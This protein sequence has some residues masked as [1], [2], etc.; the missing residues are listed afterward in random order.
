MKI[1]NKGWL[2]SYL[3]ARIG[4]AFEPRWFFDESRPADH[5]DQALYRIL[6]PTGLIYGQPIHFDYNGSDPLEIDEKVNIQVLMAESFINATLLAENKGL[7][8][9]GALKEVADRI[10]ELISDFYHSLYPE[11]SISSWSLLGG[12]RSKSEMAEKILEK[13][14][15]IN[16][17]TKE[18][19]WINFFQ[20]SFLFLDI[21]MFAKW[22]NIKKDKAVNE[23]FRQEKNDFRFLVTKIIA[24]AAHANEEIEE[25]EER[26]FE[27]FVES[28]NLSPDEKAKAY[29]SFQNGISLQEID[30]PER[31]SWI[32]KKYLLE[33]AIMTIWTDRLVES[34]EI[35]FLQDLRKALDINEDDFEMSMIAIEGFVLGHWEEFIYL[36]NK[37]S[38]DRLSNQYSAR[39]KEIVRKNSD[40]ISNQVKNQEKLISLIKK[41]ETAQ[42]EQEEKE[43]IRQELILI[44]KTIPAF[45]VVALPE[46]VMDLPML[47]KVIPTELLRD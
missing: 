8:D 30:L 3:E 19:F 44:L 5:P 2:N 29:S 20:N 39:L 46:S 31:E 40:R 43:F 9:H 6:Q 33:V 32:V 47:M 12:K 37:N 10:P 7:K 36:K 38:F 24:A 18:N 34:S 45:S 25:E 16:P 27:Y 35:A 28:I 4:G 41:A 21:F 22:L 26:F 15:I 14:I 42:L 1:K 23:F 17:K 13:R 11:L